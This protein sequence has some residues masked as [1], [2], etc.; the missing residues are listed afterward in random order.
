MDTD[1]KTQDVARAVLEII[2][3]TM[4]T[5]GAAM[6]RV[7]HDLFPGH[8]RVLGMCS[9]RVWTLRELAEAQGVTSPTMSRTVNV[10]VT[11]GWLTRTPS[12]QDRREVQIGLTPHG[13][14]VFEE[15]QHKIQA[16]IAALLVHLSPGEL[17][18]MLDGLVILRDAF[19]AGIDAENH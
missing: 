1:P 17:E 5:V 3:L 11:R 12:E 6:R 16:H 10:L 2:P 15:A 8:M 13:Q 14:E 9:K 7:G 4:R 18:S 19:Q